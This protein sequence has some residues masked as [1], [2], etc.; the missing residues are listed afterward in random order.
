ML[1]EADKS[2]QALE[3]LDVVTGLV[4]VQNQ[5]KPYVTIAV[6]NNTK[7]DITLTRMMALGT[8]QPAE[9]IV[10]AEAQNEPVLHP[11]S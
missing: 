3:A 10:V 4:K 11:S 8:L 9:W 6:A 2:S 1:L 5:A 7:H